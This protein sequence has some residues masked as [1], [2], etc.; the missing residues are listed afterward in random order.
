MS[1]EWGPWIEHGG[2]RVPDVV[3][4]VVHCVYKDGG[5]VIDMAEG[6]PA[7]WI[8]GYSPGFIPII[9]YRIRKPR[10]LV[11]LEEIANGVRQPEDA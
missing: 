11:I 7:A 2:T 10:G 1:E 4:K 8:A 6:N 9:R 3:G 5:E